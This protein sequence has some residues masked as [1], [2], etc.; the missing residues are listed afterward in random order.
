MRARRDVGVAGASGEGLSAKH[1]LN[2]DLVVGRHAARAVHIVWRNIVVETV[3]AIVG[4]GEPRSWRRKLLP[5]LKIIHITTT[6]STLSSMTT[7]EHN[8][9]FSWRHR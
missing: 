5:F 6:T 3:D 1:L 7:P 4:E 2:V 9:L 8:H